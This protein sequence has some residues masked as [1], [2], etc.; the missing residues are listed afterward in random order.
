[1]IFQTHDRTSRVVI[2]SCKM[3]IMYRPGAIDT[4]LTKAQI[5]TLA[6]SHSE[7]LL[8]EHSDPLSHYVDI[9][10]QILYLNQ[11]LEATKP[12]AIR[13]ALS[14]GSRS[15]EYHRARVQVCSRTTYNYSPDE[16]WGAIN[17]RFE[18]IKRAKKERESLLQRIPSGGKEITDATTGVVEVLAAPIRTVVPQLVVRI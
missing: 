2:N 14:T 12:V 6:T 18:Q 17:G 3:E 1:M 5:I 15:L 4:G 13:Q 10:R 16:G 9:K 8:A 7:R 11:L